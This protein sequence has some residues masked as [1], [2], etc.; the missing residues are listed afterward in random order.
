[1]F[2][3][4][5][6]M[7]FAMPKIN[8][9][10]FSVATRTSSRENNRQIVLNLIR[11][12]QP[13]SR[14]DLARCMHVTR[15]VVGVLVQELIVQGVICE[16]ATGEPSRG[17]KANFLHLRTRD[18]L[19]IAVDVGFPKTCL[20]LCDLSGRQ[21]AVETYDTIFPVTEFVRDLAGRIRR[22]LKIQNS[23][24]A[25][26]GIGI[27]VPGMVNHRTG[28]ILNAPSLGWQG[29]E[30]RAKLAAATGL[31]VHVEDSGRACA[32]AQLWFEP[33]E[34]SDDHSFVYISVSDGV[35]V[36][37]VVNGEL[38]QGRDDIAS[39]FRHLPLNL[40]GP[41]C[42]CEGTGCWEAYTSNLATLSRYFGWNLSK[43]GAQAF[44]EKKAQ[45][46]TVLDLVARARSG[47]KKAVA[48]LQATGR[49]LGLG[50]AA[51]VNVV[52][53]DCI[54]LAGEITTAW[55]LIENSVRDAMSERTLTAAAA[56]T[57]LRVT[58]N[59][60]YPRLRGAAALIA[61][62]TFAAPRVA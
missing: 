13:I 37:I 8:T 7:Q 11:D 49:F 16:G 62:R 59:Q 10:D 56:R 54:Y 53:P 2:P 46:F 51:I 3:R 21:L 61:A 47:D 50:L 4:S 28:E 41:N 20:M 55:D 60:D 33:H 36:G 1:M 38:L 26:E 24:L 23:G 15:G 40:D 42:M 30:I 48:A 35:S 14:A 44:R 12:R 25:C 32:L 19:A 43:P 29:V 22:I 6:Q 17:R 9:R 57:P 52:N 18:R 58:S 31:P 34:A 5:D 45:A 39:E 27:V